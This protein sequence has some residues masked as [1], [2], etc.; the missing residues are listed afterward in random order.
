MKTTLPNPT[1]MNQGSRSSSKDSEDEKK[2]KRVPNDIHMIKSIKHLDQV[3]LDLN[4][5]RFRE[6]CNN[7]GITIDECQKK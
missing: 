6:A 5:P 1:M 7:L 3:E 4:S 2:K